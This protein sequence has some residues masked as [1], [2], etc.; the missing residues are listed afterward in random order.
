[1]KNIEDLFKSALKDQELPY[2]E[3]AWNQ[4]SKKLDARG[5]ASGNLKWILGATGIAV[6]AV[7]T[8][9]YVSNNEHAATSIQKE[10]PVL[11]ENNKAVL[12]E[13]QDRFEKNESNVVAEETNENSNHDQAKVSNH[14]EASNKAPLSNETTTPE[15]PVE[16][17]PNYNEESVVELIDPVYREVESSNKKES[18]RFQD[19]KDHCLHEKLSYENKNK[20][21]IWLNTPNNDLHEIYASEKIQRTL[22]LKGIYQIGFL[23]EN[24]EF[25]SQ[26]SFNVIES[27]GVQLLTDDQLDYENGLPE[28][29]TNAYHTGNNTWYL[30]GELAARNQSSNSF[31]LFKKGKQLISLETKD[32]NGCTANS[33]IQFNV[34]K[35]YNL[36]AVNAFT[37]SSWD[38]RNTHFIP[39]ALTQRNTP[40]K[41]IVIDPADGAIL[42]ETSSA[43]MPWDGTDRNTGKM[44][45]ENKSYVWK[46]ILEQP[47]ANEK[48][49]YI[50]T[51]VRL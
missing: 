27:K 42:F 8:L 17:L 7:A 33:S 12:E 46:V 44:V 4:M 25:V 5:G 50:G 37:P 39:F 41:M 49:E 6:L 24:E 21:S 34:E 14:K 2:N 51:I 28:L 31:N 13:E 35:D 36:L 47:E 22:D 19:V 26:A 9:W 32:I 48:P 40:F 45:E 18:I 16:Y 29:N 30:N 10:T 15:T 20:S 11:S 23:D 1:M 43:E 3:S 38:S